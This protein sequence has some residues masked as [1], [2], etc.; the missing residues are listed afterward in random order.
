MSLFGRAF[1]LP[2]ATLPGQTV[3]AAEGVTVS[4]G[5]HQILRGVDLAVRAGE[6]L[7]LVGPNGAGKS[8]LLAAMTG[9]VDSGGRVL[10]DGAPIGDWTARELA[11]R[12]GVLTQRIEVTFPFSSVDVVRM[13]RAPWAGT[14][15]EDWDDYVVAEAMAEAEVLHLAAR[16]FNTL[17]G[18]ERART[19]FARVLAQEP[20][21]L[22]LDEPTAALD[23][24][25][26]ESLM[27][28][29]RARAARGD[30]FVVVMHDLGLAAAYADEIAVM[31]TGRIAAVGPPAQVLTS[32]LLSSVYEHPIEVWKHPRTGEVVVLPVRHAL[33]DKVSQKEGH[34][35]F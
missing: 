19:G 22:M 33:L 27:R 10:V 11:V 34:S 6:V 26:Q 18:G 16:T 5:G 28:L 2:A 21:L 12:R 20:S 15:A 14:P 30:A 23:V 4:L 24:K 3:L 8:T 1:R 25:H 35:Y 29:V 7:A 13:G 32:E 31:S 9:D 17:S